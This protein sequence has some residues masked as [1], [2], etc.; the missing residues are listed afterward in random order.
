MKLY[1]ALS[2]EEILSLYN[3]ETDLTGDL[4]QWSPSRWS[5]QDGAVSSNV[6]FRSFCQK[7]F[8]QDVILIPDT[9]T[10]DNAEF[11]CNFLSGSLIMAISFH[12]K[13][14]PAR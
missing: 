14:H 1:R 4:V 8:A 7:T 11:I 6:N 3:C 2:E 10:Y 12:S 5:L 13:F 9:V